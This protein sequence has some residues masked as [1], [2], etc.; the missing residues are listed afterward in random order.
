MSYV[1]HS[2]ANLTP[3]ARRKLACLVIEQ[4]WTLRLGRGAVPMLAGNGEKMG[5][6]LPDPGRGRHG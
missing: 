5:G 2:N 3:K 4:G 1:T 6:P